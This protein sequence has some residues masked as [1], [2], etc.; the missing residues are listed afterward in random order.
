[1]TTRTEWAWPELV[2]AEWLHRHTGDSNLRVLDATTLMTPQPVGPSHIT[3]GGT[4][5]ASAHIPT[6][7]HVCMVADFSDPVGAYP[8][9]LPTA[10]Q[11]A[12][13]CQALGIDR[14]SHV[15]IYTASQPMVATRVW[16]VLKSW[17]LP[18]VS[19]LD[20]GLPHWQACGYTLDTTTS[21]RVQ[22]DG[23]TPVLQASWV[24]DAQEVMRAMSDPECVLINALS[25]PQ[26]AGSGGAHYGRPGRIPGSI[27]V[28][29][30]AMFEPDSMIWKRPKECH[31][32]FEASGM[33]PGS[34]RR[35]IVYCGGGIAASVIFFALQ[36]LGHERVALYDNSL[37]EWST[38]PEYPMATG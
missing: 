28:P 32:L 37:L 17:G 38:Q 6:S 7:Q 36:Q 27:H 1:M 8:Y 26:F 11:V 9:T 3:H 16:W 35:A 31:A 34:D 20:G 2:S 13:R 30:A 24:A 22:A 19:I 4:L 5:W 10:T 29:A 14:D 21:K 18:H 12:N 23:F 15:V 33:R 25:A